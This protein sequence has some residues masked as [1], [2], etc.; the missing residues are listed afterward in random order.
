MSLLDDLLDAKTEFLQDEWD[1]WI[2]NNWKNRPNMKM[3]QASGWFCDNHKLALEDF[4]KL[5]RT[6]NHIAHINC[7]VSRYIAA[8]LPTLNTHLWN[9]NKTPEELLSICQHQ[10]LL[11]KPA[12]GHKIKEEAKARISNYRDKALATLEKMGRLQSNDAHGRRNWRAAK[13]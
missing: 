3:G 12:D 2:L 5:K 13:P 11:S 6:P 7:S 10:K 8:Y 4:N 1:K 9:G